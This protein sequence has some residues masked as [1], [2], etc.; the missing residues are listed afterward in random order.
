MRILKRR[1]RLD[2]LDFS[3]LGQQAQAAGELLDH[4]VLEGAQ[5]VQ[6]DL[7]CG[8][9]DAPTAGVAR[10]INQFGNVQQRLRRNAAAVEAH[11]AG[12][13]FRVDEGDAQAQIG[14]QERGRIAPRAS[15]DDGDVQIGGFGHDGGSLQSAA[16]TGAPLSSPARTIRTVARWLRRSSAGNARR[17]RHRSNGGRKRARAATPAAARTCHRSTRAPCSN[18]TAPESRLRDGSRWVKNRCRRCR[19]GW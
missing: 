6:I 11:P 5:A 13:Q 10:L 15:P 17:R 16:G 1:P 8:E 19:R 2:V 14:G 18:A 12:I 3:L 9:L 7:G 4:P